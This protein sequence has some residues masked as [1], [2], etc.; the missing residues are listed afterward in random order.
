MKIGVRYFAALRDQRGLGHEVLDLDS[1]TPSSIFESL[2]T[3]YSFS[4]AESQV[5]YAVN[6]SYVEGSVLL[7][8]GDELVIVPPVAGG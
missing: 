4:L 7:Q 6:G 2:R 5:R 8:E 1:P 3:E